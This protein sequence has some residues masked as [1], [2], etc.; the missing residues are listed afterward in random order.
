MS[1]DRLSYQLIVPESASATVYRQSAR[2]DQVD[3]Y[4]EN[5]MRNDND[6]EL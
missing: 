2:D 4:L 6:A 5:A 3:D 1:G